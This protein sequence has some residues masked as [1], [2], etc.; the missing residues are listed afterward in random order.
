MTEHT[1]STLYTRLGGYDAIAGVA[2]DL[3]PR[4]MADAQIGRFWAPRAADS[5][6]TRLEATI[7][8]GK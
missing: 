8:L 7:W 3:L 2:D 4:L 1:T 5:I 6:R